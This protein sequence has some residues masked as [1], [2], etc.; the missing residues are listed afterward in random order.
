M[1]FSDRIGITKPPDVFQLNSMNDELR[2]SLWNAIAK[3]IKPDSSTST[4]KKFLEDLFLRFFKESITSL[5]Y[6]DFDCRTNL[7]NRFMQLK[8]Y[9]TYNLLEIIIKI[10]ETHSTKINQKGFVELINYILKEELAGYTIINGLFVQITNPEEIKSIE[11]A[12]STPVTKGL[13]NVSEHITTAVTLLSKKP[14]ADY[15]NSIKESISAVEG[16]CK[17]I[18]GVNSGGLKEALNKLSESI[19]IHSALKEA[20][21]KIYGYT[22]DEGGIRHPMLEDN[23]VG[24]AEAKYMLVSCSA[25]VNYIVDKASKANLI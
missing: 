1:K 7:E 25:F 18:T 9:D 6:S 5:P 20:Y 4:F 2:N 16:I 22:S 13:K 8:W 17:M 15:K 21:L 23:N 19:E 3:T 10:V 12:Q 24:F 11:D 14:S